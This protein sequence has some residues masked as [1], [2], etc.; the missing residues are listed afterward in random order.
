MHLHKPHRS[1]SSFTTVSVCKQRLKGYFLKD[2]IPGRGGKRKGC[3]ISVCKDATSLLLRKKSHKGELRRC[4]A[5]NLR[6]RRNSRT[7]RRTPGDR[8]SWPPYDFTNET[9]SDQWAGRNPLD[10]E[11]FSWKKRKDNSFKTTYL[12]SPWTSN[13]RGNSVN[14]FLVSFHRH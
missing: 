12:L 3:A 13:I 9:C 4:E 5:D 7:S 11:S 10:F 1:S 8:A 6:I 14:I 2:V